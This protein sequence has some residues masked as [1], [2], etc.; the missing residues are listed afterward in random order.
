MTL[1]LCGWREL[2]HQ[3]FECTL[4]YVCIHIYTLFFVPVSEQNLLPPRLPICSNESVS[5]F[6]EPLVLA[7]WLGV[8]SF[9]IK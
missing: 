7:S 5:L 1:D 3:S 8:T 6:T 4:A 9:L 2:E